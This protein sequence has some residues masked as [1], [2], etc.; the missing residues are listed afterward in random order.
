MNRFFTILF[1]FCTS[2]FL[3]AQTYQ[4][5]QPALNKLGIIEGKLFK[6]TQNRIDSLVLSKSSINRQFTDRSGN[7]VYLTDF[8]PS[9]IPIYTSVFNRGAAITTGVSRLQEDI[10]FGSPL[11]GLGVTVGI[12]DGGRVRTDHI[13]FTDRATQNDAAIEF[14]DHAT[15]VTGTIG[16][17]GTNINAKGMAPACS[18]RVW[19]FQNDLSEMSVSASQLLLSNHSYGTIRGWHDGS[20]F[21]DPSVSNIEDYLFGFYNGKSR[22]LDQ[23]SF[24]APYYLIVWAAGNDRNDAGSGPQPPDGNSGTGFDSIGPEGIAKN[25]LTVG[26]VSKVANYNTPSDVIMSP[27][28]SW[29]PTDD[30]RIK[31]DLVGAGV[32]LTSTFSTSSASY[33]V[34]SGTSMAAPNITGSLALVQELY[35]RL[36][37]GKRFRASTLKGLAIH[38]A[39]EAGLFMGPDYKFGWGLLDTYE[40]GSII[41]RNSV[42]NGVVI[43]EQ[44]LVQGTTF[45]IPIE[46]LEGT[47]VRVTLSWT[48]PAGTPVTP[49]LDPS[50]RMLVNDLDV[51]IVDDDGNVILP[52][53]LDPAFPDAMATK[54]INFR[55][56]VEKIDFDNPLPRKYYAKVEHKGILQGGSQDFSL[57]IDYVPS[58]ES[59]VPLY[60]VGGSGEWNNAQHWSR[61]SGGPSSN[62]IPTKE[63]RVII[64]NNSMNGSDE[65]IT[66]NGTGLCYSFTWLASSD[67]G[68]LVLSQESNLLVESDL[69][70]FSKAKF[71]GKGK[72]VLKGSKDINRI[73]LNGTDLNEIIV[74]I[75][76]SKYSIDGNFSGVGLM[77][78]NSNVTINGNIKVDTLVV[79]ASSAFNFEN[80]KLTIN[81]GVFMEEGALISSEG[82]KIIIPSGSNSIFKTN[83]IFNSWVSIEPSS[84]MLVLSGKQFSRLDVSGTL[85]IDYNL[86]IKTDSIYVASS[87]KITLE[88]E[89][90][91]LEVDKKMDLEEGATIE[92]SDW[93]GGNGKISYMPEVKLCFDFIS[94]NHVDLLTDS[95]IVVGLNSNVSN[96]SNWIVDNCDEVL[97][98]DFDIDFACKGG[99]AILSNTSNGNF[100]QSSWEIDGK[101]VSTDFNTFAILPNSNHIEVSLTIGNGQL[102]HV[103]KRIIQLLENPLQNNQIILENSKLF[104][105]KTSSSYQ[106][107]LNLDS[108]KGQINRFLEIPSEPGL[109]QVAIVD[110][111]C[112]N[113]SLPFVITNAN[114]ELGIYISPNPTSGIVIV[115]NSTQQPIKFTLVNLIGNI[116]LEANIEKQSFESFDLKSLSDGIYIYTIQ[117]VGSDDLHAF[118]GRL[119]KM[120]HD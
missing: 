89:T 18:M 47:R 10:S 72:I 19:D 34:L 107:F 15:H 41:V 110:Q 50:T 57:I 46:P 29:G 120:N 111:S 84:S 117:G 39:K 87:G 80:K 62:E 114:D 36:N 99:L 112:A 104:S 7:K 93:N 78:F 35:A 92:T 108:I 91:I 73:R 106:W 22:S 81:K 116:F 9:G 1:C 42:Q 77:L 60:W 14:D 2:T 68:G 44:N 6:N 101:L 105:Q 5:D 45:Q 11:L 70:F 67:R 90:S 109:Y 97:F 88:D 71:T 59:E 38:T 25:V 100:L 56:N 4:V 63:T 33:G 83:N 31:P 58:N 37:G 12:W 98:A 113:L 65:R 61:T 40:A 17:F 52:W 82:S 103:R 51:S 3:L 79:N 74:S 66:I 27:F 102:E 96:S 20:W 48:D 23:I 55:D 115:N 16:A 69:S 118:R 95:R 43:E 13:E 54:A 94:I 26:A 24:S 30:G 76:N 49:S 119:I 53:V 86:S 8:F 85:K 64:D 32:N 28:S 21:G 75:M